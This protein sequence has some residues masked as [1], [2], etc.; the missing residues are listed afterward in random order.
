M[1][2]RMMIKFNLTY[3]EGLTCILV[4]A[5]EGAYLKELPHPLKVHTP[6]LEIPLTCG[7][8]L[9]QNLQTNLT[10]RI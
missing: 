7:K 10:W 8:K 9:N 6:Y 1:H 4:K 3:R 5:N 2:E